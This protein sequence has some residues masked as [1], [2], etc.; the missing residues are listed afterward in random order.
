M[1]VVVDT[2][3]N[4]FESVFAAWPIR[5]YVI[6]NGELVFKAQP[7]TVHYAYDPTDLSKWLKDNV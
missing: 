7:N 3:N 5:F 6:K 2:L 4:E 1:P